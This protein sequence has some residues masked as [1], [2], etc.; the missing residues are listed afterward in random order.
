MELSFHYDHLVQKDAPLAQK[1][2]RQHTNKLQLVDQAAKI[3]NLTL[4]FLL[5]TQLKLNLCLPDVRSVT[6]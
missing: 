6:C 1:E 4:H 5:R 2:K 3:R